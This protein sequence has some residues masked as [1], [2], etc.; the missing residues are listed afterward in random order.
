[1]AV[2]VTAKTDFQIGA[3]GQTRDARIVV[4]GDS[5]FA[6]NGQVAAIPG[7]LNFILN[8]MAWLTENEELIAIRPTGKDDL[9]V[10]LS[11][12]DQRLIAWV[13][14]LG[15]VQTVIVAGFVVHLLRR[16]YQ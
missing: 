1:M 15:T 4:V 9:P 12:F 14:V 5:D 6:S 2:A 10:M 16:K 7:N 3:S 11:D 8:I 13:A